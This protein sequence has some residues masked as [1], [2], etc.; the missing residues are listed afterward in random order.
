MTT[1]RHLVPVQPQTGWG[2]GPE[3]HGHP[4]ADFTVE[5]AF[6]L[7]R[8]IRLPGA[9]PGTIA[10]HKL[11]HRRLSNF[12]GREA[13]IGDIN[14]ATIGEMMAWM[15]DEGRAPATINK[16]RAVWKALGDFLARQGLG[17]GIEIG[18]VTVVAREPSALTTEDVRRLIACCDSANFM[19]NGV[20]EGPFFRALILFIYCTGE[21]IGAVLKARFDDLRGHTLLIRGEN[22]KG[23]RA[24]K[25]HVLSAECLEAIEAIREPERAFVFDIPFTEATLTNRY[26]KL[27]ESAGIPPEPRNKWHKLRKTCATAVAQRAGIEAASDALGHANVQVTRQHYIDQRIAKPTSAA[28]ILPDVAGGNTGAIPPATNG[29][30]DEAAEA[31]TGHTTQTDESELF[32]WV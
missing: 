3:P 1:S 6:H 2:G 9:K 14:D 20:Q 10:H 4:G 16:A 19:A 12:L 8:S 11:E 32:S 23:G 27:C 25:V 31:P 28:D 17:R 29:A 7:Y 5:R 30:P 13:T 15:A 18:C 22:R 24:D 21:R 26:D